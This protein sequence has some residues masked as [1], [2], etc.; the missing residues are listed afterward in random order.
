MYRVFNFIRRYDEREEAREE[1]RK[2]AAEVWANF[3]K[4]MTEYRNKNKL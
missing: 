1:G 3:D 2:A 4:R